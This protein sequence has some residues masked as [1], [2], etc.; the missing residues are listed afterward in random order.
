MNITDDQKETYRADGAICLRGVFNKHWIDV[1]T[2]GIERLLANPSD[3]AEAIKGKT[4]PGSYFNDFG[5]W[6]RIPEFEDFVRNSPAGKLVGQLVGTKRVT[7]YHEHVLIKEP[8]TLK[9]TPWHHDQ[10]YYP[11]NGDLVASIWMPLD[12]VPLETSIQF[13][14]GSHKW[15]KW[16]YPRKFESFE[17]YTANKEIS[18]QVFEKVPDIDSEINKH[19][20]LSWAVEPGDCV[21]FHMKALHTAPGN[22]NMERSR[23]VLSTRWLGDDACIAERPWDLPLP[24]IG[25]LSPGDPVVS[26]MFPTVW[27]QA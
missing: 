13:V 3:H 9:E 22:I 18:G 25:G 19:E 12:P 17:S 4:G 23:R 5:N 24:I 16:F 10:S 8:G 21:V 26:D 11:I 1:A 15:G 20:I 7:F 2:E 27:S 14:K 6:Q